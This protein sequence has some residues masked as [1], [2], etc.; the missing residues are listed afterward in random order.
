MKLAL[1]SRFQVTVHLCLRP[2]TASSSAYLKL[3]CAVHK[4]RRQ[5]VQY[6]IQVHILQTLQ[7][8]HLI[9]AR[10]EARNHQPKQPSEPEYPR[11]LP[12]ALALLLQS[13]QLL[14]G[15]DAQIRRSSLARRGRGFAR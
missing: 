4:A 12:F 11:I 6:T 3:L 15:D 13:V 10:K 1:V 8:N 14:S 5:R 7:I 2:N 9:T